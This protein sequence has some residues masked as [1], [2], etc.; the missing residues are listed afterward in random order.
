M[1]LVSEDKTGNLWFGTQ[2]GGV[3]RYDGKSFTTFSTTQGLANNWVNNIVEDKAGN[4]WFGT[5]G[6]G[7]SRY[8]GKS[9]ILFLP[10]RGWQ[11]IL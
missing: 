10:P 8:D 5:L 1:S 9:F 3:S 2:G 4:L 6:G 11:I 7:V